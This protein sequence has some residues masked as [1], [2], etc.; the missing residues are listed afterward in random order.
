[1]SEHTRSSVRMPRE[2]RSIRP[3]GV[4]HLIS[5]FVDREWFIETSDEREYYLSLLGRALRRCDWRLLAYA[6]MSNHIHLAAIAGQMP[7]DQW[8]R[9]VHSPFAD[10]LNR[11][12]NRIGP[13]FARG[14][15]DGEIAAHDVGHLIAYIHNNPVRA[16]VCATPRDTDWTS[17]RAF[18]GAASVPDWLHVTDALSLSQIERR[19]F[20][21]WVTDPARREREAEFTE[22]HYE[23]KRE[24]AEAL[25]LQ[26]AAATVDSRQPIAAD[27]SERLVVLAA[28]AFDLSVDQLRSRTRG[29]AEIAARTAVVQAGTRLGLTGAQIARALNLSQQRVSMLRRLP[30]D[31]AAD[32]S[33]SRMSR[34]SILLEEAARLSMSTELVIEDT[35]RQLVQVEV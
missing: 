3:G 7:L 26:A 4:Y 21:T 1:M 9:R 23:R 24:E 20:H 11:S 32:A 5:R 25:A 2:A 31:E 22:E 14:P 15:K 17:H 6:I 35:G 13:V 29:T 30:L 34:V 10:T 19:D 16:E 27:V 33:T 28:E 8:L 12:H 18:I